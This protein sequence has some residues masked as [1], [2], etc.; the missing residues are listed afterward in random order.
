M[1]STKKADELLSRA[2]EMANVKYDIIP[3][4]LKGGLGSAVDYDSLR[5]QMTK[6]RGL[7]NPPALI[8]PK[9]ASICTNELYV[10]FAPHEM[11]YAKNFYHLNSGGHMV[12]L[13]F[14]RIILGGESPMISWGSFS[15]CFNI[16]IQE[17]P[18]GLLYRFDTFHGPPFRY[19]I[20]LSKRFNTL[21]FM[22]KAYDTNSCLHYSPI[23]FKNG[24]SAY[25]Y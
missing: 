18:T 10:E 16:Q 17:V 21:K 13:D 24:E 14:N 3:E 4:N 25:Q 8:D 2:M 12:H 19:Y 23:A 6:Y 1:T 20:E 5:R 15:N 9:K 7:P 22:S 11:V